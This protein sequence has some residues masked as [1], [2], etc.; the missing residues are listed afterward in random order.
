M[1]ITK[2]GHETSHK[3]KRKWLDELWLLCGRSSSVVA[4]REK[5]EQCLWNNM[6]S[7][8]VDLYAAEK[9]PVPTHLHPVTHHLR[10]ATS[11]FSVSNSSI[12]CEVPLVFGLYGMLKIDPDVTSPYAVTASRKEEEINLETL[13]D[14]TKMASTEIATFFTQV[15][16]A[17][18]NQAHEVIVFM[19][20]EKNR[21][22]HDSTPYAYPLA[23]ALKGKSMGNADL[24]YLVTIVKRGY[25]FCVRS[26]MANGNSLLLL[27]QAEDTSQN[28]RVGTF[29]T[30]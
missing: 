12:L 24:R 1:C 9:P 6:M 21:I 8:A 23:F 19:I 18:R 25:R 13:N 11:A 4:M 14:L 5:F 16:T 15:H 17:L 29:G 30:K 22:Q 10:E 7:V 20:T 28:Y 2:Y 26:M 27:M 3:W